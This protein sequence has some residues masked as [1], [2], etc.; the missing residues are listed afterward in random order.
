MNVFVSGTKHTYIIVKMQHVPKQSLKCVSNVISGNHT[1]YV[2]KILDLTNSARV[3]ASAAIATLLIDQYRLHTNDLC[4][5]IRLRYATLL[6]SSPCAVTVVALDA[7]DIGQLNM[8]HISP[9]NSS[10]TVTLDSQT[11][12][13]YQ[14]MSWSLSCGTHV[15]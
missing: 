13:R 10:F 7:V 5:R 2:N 15:V 4:S 8:R 6:D 3:L 14:Y 11:T 1:L 12:T 9:Q